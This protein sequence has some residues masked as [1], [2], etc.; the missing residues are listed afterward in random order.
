MEHLTL[1]FDRYIY[2]VPRAGLWLG[3]QPPSVEAFVRDHYKPNLYIQAMDESFGYA[4]YYLELEEF[5]LK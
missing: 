4:E 1:E 5:F 2:Y 3:A